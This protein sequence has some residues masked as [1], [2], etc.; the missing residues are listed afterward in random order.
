MEKD[1][2]TIL[3]T[4]DEIDETIKKISLSIIEDYKEK[5]PVIISIMDGSLFFCRDLLQHL[6]FPLTINSLNVSSYINDSHSENLCLGPYFLTHVADKHIVLVDDMIDTGNTIGF[7]K[8]F[9]KKFNPKSLEVCTL[10]RVKKS[11][12]AY[13]PFVKYVGFDIDDGSLVGYGM[14]FKEKYRNLPCVG[15]LKPH[16]LK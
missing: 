7:V 1:I 12:S 13:R 15:Y 3:Y 9:L 4:K 14:D 8:N 16:L 5:N 11:R 2:I 6:V 10:F